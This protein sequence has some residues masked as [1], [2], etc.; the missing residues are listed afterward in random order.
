MTNVIFMQMLNLNL[1]RDIQMDLDYI[2]YTSHQH[3]PPLPQST[4]HPLRRPLHLMD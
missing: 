2:T 4:H 1:I 3:P